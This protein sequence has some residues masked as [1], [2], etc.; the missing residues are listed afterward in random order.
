MSEPVS[1]TSDLWVG[2]PE[3]KQPK[4]EAFHMCRVRFEDQEALDAF[5]ELI[6]QKITAK[7]KST[8]MP[9]KPRGEHGCKRYYDGG[10]NVSE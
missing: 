7:T 4:K 1:K 5:S 6:G 3:F 9:E 10:G 2:M 8:W